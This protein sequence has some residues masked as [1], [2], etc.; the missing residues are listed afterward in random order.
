MARMA[1]LALLAI[2]LASFLSLAAATGQ[3]PKLAVDGEKI[4]AQVREWPATS[5]I[6]AVDDQSA[7][8]AA[9]QARH[10]HRPSQPGSDTDF[11]HSE[12]HARE[13]V[14]PM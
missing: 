14:G 13:E 4:V 9:D 7:I 10:F 11:V 3:A 5:I 6:T 12:R 8:A 1:A 2:E